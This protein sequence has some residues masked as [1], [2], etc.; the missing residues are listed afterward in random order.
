M[1]MDRCSQENHGDSIWN[2]CQGAETVDHLMYLSK[3]LLPPG[4]STHLSQSDASE[5]SGSS[6]GL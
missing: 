2:I 1:N 3:T 4:P 6:F 5:K